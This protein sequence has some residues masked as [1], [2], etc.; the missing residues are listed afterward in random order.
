MCQRVAH[1]HCNRCAATPRCRQQKTFS[2]MAASS[3]SKEEV[4]A[5]QRLLA[6]IDGLQAIMVADNDGVIVSHAAAPDFEGAEQ[7]E[8]ALTGTFASVAGQ[9]AKL[10]FGKQKSLTSFFGDRM[11]VHVNLTPL[12]ISFVGSPDTNVGLVHAALD[13]LTQILEPL[14]QAVIEAN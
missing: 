5:L 13:E 1:A 9:I 2:K 3:S 11:V 6:R 4:A 12:V 8:V 10:G 7:E 14:R